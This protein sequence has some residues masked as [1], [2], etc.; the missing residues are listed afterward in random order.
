[1]R[2]HI[3]SCPQ[4]LPPV[5]LVSDP[6]IKQR[7]PSHRATFSMGYAG[8]SRKSPQDAPWET[9]SLRL[10]R[11]ISA[12]ILTAGRGTCGVPAYSWQ[13]S[14]QKNVKK[15]IAE[16]YLLF[17]V[18]HPSEILAE[19][20]RSKNGFSEPI[21]KRTGVQTD[22]VSAN[23]WLWERVKAVSRNLKQIGT[24]NGWVSTLIFCS[25]RKNNYV[26]L[27]VLIENKIILFYMNDITKP[28]ACFRDGSLY[29]LHRADTMYFI[30]CMLWVM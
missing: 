15:M 11:P 5:S 3:F 4:V 22:R 26:V 20:I 13:L 18:S 8:A 27:L 23:E 30:K 19:P 6:D 10:S 7:K 29:T 1:M 9:L 21:H 25:L 24:N 14:C 16:V 17:L 2:Q 28:V 12:P